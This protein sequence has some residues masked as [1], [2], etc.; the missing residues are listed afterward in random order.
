MST[1][2]GSFSIVMPTHR[3]PDSL[4]QVLAALS[5]QDFPADRFEV[6]VV[7]DGEGPATAAS[8]DGH[9]YPF[10]LQVLHQDHAGPAAARNR[11]VAAAAE[12]YLLFLDDDVIP[13][14]TLIRRH[15]EAHAGRSDRV[16][17]GPLLAAG[18]R[19]A[20][21]TRWEWATLARQ[22]RAMAEGEWQPTPRQFY[23]GNASVLR[24]HVVAAGGFNP[25]FR[26]GEDVELAWR[27][28]ALGLEF[29]FEPRAEAA[30]LARRSFQA[31]LQAAF[32][33]G[34]TDVL[35][36]R[37]RTGDDLPG[38]VRR[39]FAERHRY[40]RRLAEIALTQARLW[41]GIPA[42][43]LVLASVASGLGLTRIANQTCS[44]LFT[45]AYWR[46]VAAQ[47]GSVEAALRLMKPP[48][49]AV[50]PAELAP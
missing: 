5:R 33:Y 21:W 22:Y 47:L 48:P 18:S 9:G 32:E 2:T 17:I 30:H 12:P 13:A 29:V 36:E 7:F 43:G 4:L 15:A 45:A 11:A 41:Q 27:L 35:L 44:A 20:P 24:E 42:T 34:R 19:G 31:W 46:G 37:K 26:R 1:A 23:T 10:R 25:E 50:S 14:P 3:R 49:P 39:E 6:I 28:K 40:T 8:L 38:W 16:V